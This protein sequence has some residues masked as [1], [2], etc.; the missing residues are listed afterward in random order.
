MASWRLIRDIAVFALGVLAFMTEVILL[1]DEQTP[2][3]LTLGI[4]TLLLGL[5]VGAITDRLRGDP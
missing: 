4:I 2:D 5:P 1:P 3:P